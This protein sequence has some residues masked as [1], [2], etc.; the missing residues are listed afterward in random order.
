[1]GLW[2]N[3]KRRNCYEREPRKRH[4]RF[5]LP[6]AVTKTTSEETEVHSAY[7]CLPR[8]ALRML[9]G[10]D[11]KPSLKKRLDAP[12]IRPRLR[13]F[14]TPRRE[15]NRRRSR[16]SPQRPPR[17]RWT[18]CSRGIWEKRVLRFCRRAGCRRSEALGWNDG[19]DARTRLRKPRSEG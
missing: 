15:S 19:G 3:R 2:R 9:S 12:S 5:P 13:R 18:R 4:P 7:P 8:R 11:N 1:L 17:R 16:Q 14:L 6:T 10:N